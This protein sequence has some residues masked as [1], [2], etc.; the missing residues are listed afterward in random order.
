MY[1]SV[2]WGVSDRGTLILSRRHSAVG[3]PV[4]FVKCEVVDRAYLFVESRSSKLTQINMFA[5]DIY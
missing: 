1:D 4:P 3:W 5:N 2:R